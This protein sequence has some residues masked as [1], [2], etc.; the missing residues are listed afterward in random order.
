MTTRTPNVRLVGG[1][2]SFKGHLGWPATKTTVGKRM[3]RGWGLGSLTED[4]R[5]AGERAESFDSVP[6]QW[7]RRGRRRLAL[8]LLLLLVIAMK[9]IASIDAGLRP[10]AGKGRRGELEEEQPRS[11]LLIRLLPQ[12][13]VLRFFA[14]E[15][16]K[17]S[18]PS[19]PSAIVSA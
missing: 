3:E 16:A 11:D 19:R 1:A 4:R 7:D 15:S 6:R 2:R 5:P 8:L 18:K 9:I 12:Y 10:S 14:V 13:L 17:L